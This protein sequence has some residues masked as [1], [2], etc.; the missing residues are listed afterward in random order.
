MQPPLGNLFP[1][2]LA[3]PH[4]LHFDTPVLAFAAVAQLVEVSLELSTTTTILLVPDES[5]ELL[6]TAALLDKGNVD[7]RTGIIAE[8]AVAAA[9]QLKFDQ[10]LFDLHERDDGRV[11]GSECRA[12]HPEPVSILLVVDLT[13]R[14]N[15]NINAVRRSRQVDS[16]H[17]ALTFKKVLQR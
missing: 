12:V 13:I 1:L 11:A 10:I 7:R 8:S 14:V 4:A 5:L 9:A 3:R 2:D 15:P 17:D 6:F 16:R